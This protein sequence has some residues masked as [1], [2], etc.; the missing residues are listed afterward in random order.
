MRNP[1]ILR[2]GA[3]KA[4]SPVPRDDLLIRKGEKEVPSTQ[5]PEALANMSVFALQCY[6]CSKVYNPARQ[7]LPVSRELNLWMNSWK[8]L[9]AAWMQHALGQV[10]S[11]KTQI[12][13]KFADC[14]V[15][16]STLGPEDELLMHSGKELAWIVRLNWLI[17]QKQL[18]LIL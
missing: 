9:Q 15:L 5:D 6:V 8:L 10:M 4:G 18:P 2:A 7:G 3:G 13:I 16:I 11:G 14:S 1:A 17:L 12:R